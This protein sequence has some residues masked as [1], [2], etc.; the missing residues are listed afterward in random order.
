MK[1]KKYQYEL[2]KIRNTLARVRN[3]VIRERLLMVQAALK[4]PLREAAIDFGC[5]HSKLDYWKKRYL[6]HGLKGIHTLSHSGRPKKISKEDE[7]IIKRKVSKHD[8]KRG[9]RTKHVKE[10]IFRQTGVKYC[11]RQVIRISQSWGLSQVKP[12][13]HYAYAKKEDKDAFIKKTKTD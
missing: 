8:I 7:L 11:E 9:W 12:R 10:E 6:K 4:Y 3:P 1:T 13:Q 5:V 2:K